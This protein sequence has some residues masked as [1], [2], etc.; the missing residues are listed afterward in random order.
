MAEK[1]VE[2]AHEGAVQKIHFANITLP[3]RK[4]KKLYDEARKNL[5]PLQFV[6]WLIYVYNL[7]SAVMEK[8]DFELMDGTMLMYEHEK[9]RK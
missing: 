3:T 7:M 5:S 2:F 1:L 9:G 4:A 6:K 8:Q